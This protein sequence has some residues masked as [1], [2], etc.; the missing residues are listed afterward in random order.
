MAD[1]VFMYGIVVGAFAV[2]TGILFSSRAKRKS[3]ERKSTA[4]A[5]TSGGERKGAI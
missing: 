2:L 5:S 4:P 3:E 1:Q